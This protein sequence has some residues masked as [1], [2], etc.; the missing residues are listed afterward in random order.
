M[1]ASFAH[2]ERQNKFRDLLIIDGLK[3]L[4]YADR[5]PATNRIKAENLIKRVPK[6]FGE[7]GWNRG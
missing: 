4:V 5:V 6:S 2:H 7:Y 3:Q 1:G